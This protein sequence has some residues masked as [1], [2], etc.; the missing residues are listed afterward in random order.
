VPV[1]V[2]GVTVIPG[3]FV[4][5][6]GTSAVI[7]PKDSVEMILKKARNIMN[8][9]EQTKAG[10]INEDPQKIVSQGSSEL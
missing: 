9:M 5:A 2:N 1:N 6:R 3:D 4:F 7:I 8:K 10:F